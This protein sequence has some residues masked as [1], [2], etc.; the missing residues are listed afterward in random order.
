MPV[1]RSGASRAKPWN[2]ERCV[3]GRSDGRRMAAPTASPAASIGIVP[4]PAMGSTSG[5]VRASQRDSMMSCAAM[6]SRSGAGPMT[7]R[8]PRRCRAP[9][10][11]SMPT[12]VRRASG[13]PAR[14]TTNTTSGESAS[15]S[16]AT[17]RDVSASTIAF[18]TTPRSWSGEASKSCAG[19]TS[20]EKR[21]R[22]PPGSLSSDNST[23]SSSSKSGSKR[24]APLE[25]RSH[26]MRDDVR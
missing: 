24:T 1:K 23:G 22:A 12:T 25:Q 21:R 7:I 11:M 4:P 18:L 9:P 17:P 16:V 6:V 5:S 15:I 3:N 10:P 26:E 2:A 19:P 13:V 8:A 20:T 14:R